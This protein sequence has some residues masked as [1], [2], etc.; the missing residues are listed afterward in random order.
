MNSRGRGW[1]RPS[2]ATLAAMRRAS[3]RVSSLAAAR[4]PGPPRNRDVGERLPFAIAHD[5]AL[6]LQ[7]RGDGR[8]GERGDGG[9]A[10]GAGNRRGHG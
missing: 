1:G 6:L 2:L 4:R 10:R 3:S 9:G 5:E 8:A 7:P